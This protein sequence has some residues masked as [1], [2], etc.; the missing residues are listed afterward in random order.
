MIILQSVNASFLE[1]ISSNESTINHISDYFTFESPTAKFH[2][3]YRKKHWDG[4][5]RLLQ[6]GKYLY[7]GLK[8]RLVYF[9]KK[10]HYPFSDQT[11]KEHLTLPLEEISTFI[12][13]LPLPFNPR[14]YQKNS[15]LRLLKT[16]RGLL[17]SP[18]S[19]GKSLI[20]F[21]LIVS[22]LKFLK[23]KRI[24]L[25][26]PTI[27][28]VEQMFKDFLEYSKN[29][30]KLQSFFQRNTAL[31]YGDTKPHFNAA[32]RLIIGTF[33]SLALLGGEFFQ[34]VDV[35]FGDEC[36]L[37]SK[38]YGKL[39]FEG[40]T[41]ATFKMGC[42][43][44]L[45]DT[46]LDKW[47]LEGLFGKPFQLIKTHEL[48][49]NE[50]ATPVKVIPFILKYSPSFRKV[51][52]LLEYQQEYE[53]LMTIPKRT[54]KIASF[55]SELSQNTLI[56]FTRIEKHG[57][58][59]LKSLQQHSEQ[60]GKEIIYITGNTSVEEREEARQK[61]EQQNNL[62]LLCS[63]GVFAQG[64]NIKNIH[65]IVFA[66]PYKS[67]IKVLQSIGRGLRL[68][69][70]KKICFIYDFVD[71]CRIKGHTNFVFSHFLQRLKLYEEERF[72]IDIIEDDDLIA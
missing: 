10:H 51:I 34:N 2:P 66:S 19:S 26:V 9:L 31:L 12:D 61:A 24:V 22:L 18:T 20:L 72:E 56:L 62:I 70:S 11:E 45:Q 59:L 57:D 54:D 5:I 49:E 69:E 42:T 43:G 6:K 13:S 33:P 71:D 53:S 17:V 48:I 3:A 14:D 65:H 23:P 36:H 1:I 68:H 67:K 27:S 60:S 7:S 32:S 4:K 40:S 28:L 30:E 63:Y 29:S 16:K 15:V 39:I 21:L 52:S 38:Q 58:L 64:I 55:V 46:Q 47:V 25:A 50:Q 35:V 37:L 8:E 44:T 41:N